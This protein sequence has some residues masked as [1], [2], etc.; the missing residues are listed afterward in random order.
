ME[1]LNHSERSGEIAASDWKLA[2]FAQGEWVC[3]YIYK[4]KCGQL[5]QYPNSK[6][7][8]FCFGGFFVFGVL[9]FVF[10]GVFCLVVSLVYGLFVELNSSLSRYSQTALPASNQDTSNWRKYF[11]HRCS[12]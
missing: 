4:P 10:C 11:P 5:S 8:S 6:T 2:R 12:I 1:N 9:L 3:V 7:T